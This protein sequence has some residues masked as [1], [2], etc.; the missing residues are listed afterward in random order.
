MW[1]YKLDE[2]EFGPFSIEEIEQLLDTNTIQNMTPVRREGADEWTYLDE[3]DLAFLLLK[4][5]SFNEVPPKLSVLPP[6]LYHIGP[7]VRL[8]TINKLFNWFLI[9]FVATI[10]VGIFVFILAITNRDTKG[11]SVSVA[12]T[13]VGFLVL[14]AVMIFSSVINYVLMYKYW[15]IVQDGNASTTPSRAIGFLF[16]PFFNYY[17]VFRYK[18]GLSKEFNRYIDA[19]LQSPDPQN[20]HKAHPKLALAS[21]ICPFA[22]YLFASFYSFIYSISVLQ[23]FPNLPEM[24]IPQMVVYL[25]FGG[26]FI[27]AYVVLYLLTLLDL[28]KT[29]VSILKAEEGSA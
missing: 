22:Y 9:S 28:Y 21:I 3:S 14:Y 11:F 1:Y 13:L 26:L 5:P 15:Q 10:F 25:I 27:L 6:P 8:K 12:L 17:W 23:N 7:R 20:P 18:Y 19:H 16:I 24:G 2:Q 29:A 4:H